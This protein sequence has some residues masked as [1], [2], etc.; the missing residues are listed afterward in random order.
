M[1][2]DFS[3][4]WHGGLLVSE[5]L[6][7]WKDFIMPVS[8]I[9]IYLTG[10][11]LSIFPQNWLTFQLL[12][13]GIN[14]IFLILI[15]FFLNKYEKN[16]FV[17]LISL[18]LF[19]FSYL[20]LLTHP[21]YNNFAALFL[22]MA[23]FLSSLQNKLSILL[24]GVIA[25][26]TVFTKLDFGLLAF[27]SCALIILYNFFTKDGDFF[28]SALLFLIGFFA[29]SFFVISL[30]QDQTLLQTLEIYKE[31]VQNRVNRLSKLLDSKNI[32]LVSIGIWCIFVGFRANRHFILYGLIILSACATS[33]FGGLEHT[34]FYYIF[35]IPPIIF[36][37][38]KTE[39][40]LHLLILIPM[41]IS[42]LL[43]SL[44]LSAHVIENITFN[45]YESEF[46]NYRNISA[47][48]NIINLNSCSKYL[49]NVYAP[50]DFCN[51][52]EII[53]KNLNKKDYSEDPILNITELNFIGAELGI[54]PLKGHPLW[55]KTS[56]TVTK[57]LQYKIENEILAGKYKIVLLQNVEKDYSSHIT[58]KQMI[59]SLSGNEKYF[60]VNDEFDSP[61]CMIGDRKKNECAIHIFIRKTS[62]DS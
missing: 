31:T 2:R 6:S 46:F 37:C 23:I 33:I 7:P 45:H 49:K 29:C 32:F 34:H 8:P 18:A 27:S 44:R 61:M 21:W 28:K 5:G 15:F 55:Y 50:S 39:Y 43:P 35:V 14:I 58:R 25:S 24:S 60:K 36:F 9:S 26:I 54:P 57:N 11:A 40:K 59:K 4:L 1:F 16:R 47:Q 51:I 62:G 30:Y 13:L 41:F 38:Y 56:Q 20:L 19:S 42:L 52:K 48:N 10:L 12:Q 22:V 3:I 17:T 53:L